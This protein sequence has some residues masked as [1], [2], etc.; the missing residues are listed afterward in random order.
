LIAGAFLLILAAVRLLRSR[1]DRAIYRLLRFDRFDLWAM[2]FIEYLMLMGAPVMSGFAI[3]IVV[4]EANG[5]ETE[6]LGVGDA[7]WLTTV[8]GVAAAVFASMS[9]AGRNTHQFAPGT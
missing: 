4:G 7:A 5:I 9:A 8:S 6:A 3:V 1:R 2:G